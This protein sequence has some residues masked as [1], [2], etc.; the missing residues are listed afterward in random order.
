MAIFIMLCC[1]S[2]WSES[3]EAQVLI[4][5]HLYITDT[6][7]AN[8]CLVGNEWNIRTTYILPPTWGHLRLTQFYL[9]PISLYVGHNGRG[10][11]QQTGVPCFKNPLRCRSPRHICSC[12]Q[13]FLWLA[14]FSRTAIAH[15]EITT[16]PSP[17]PRRPLWTQ[18]SFF[19]N[20]RLF[21]SE[22]W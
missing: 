8:K 5:L 22:D 6:P 11:S 7:S 13:K 12:W 18:G 21:G 20:A 1:A 9:W 10:K 17:T 14:K 19:T 2:Y 15:P 16:L 4:F 3:L